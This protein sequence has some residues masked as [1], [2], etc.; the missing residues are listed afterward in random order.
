[1]RCQYQ[2]YTQYNDR[3]NIEKEIIPGENQLKISLLDVLEGPENRAMDMENLECLA[4]FTE[5]PEE[6][7]NLY[8]DNIRLLQAFE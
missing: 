4:I 7:F 2:S 3:Y 6:E 5:R 8:I 1:M